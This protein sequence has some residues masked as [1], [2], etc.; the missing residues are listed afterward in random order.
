ME[1]PSPNKN[2]LATTCTP[3][4]YYQQTFH[5]S[6]LQQTNKVR[7]S[8]TGDVST[9][10]EE[11]GVL[12]S[13]QSTHPEWQRVP[14]LRLNK[15][16]RT[17][18][19]PTSLSPPTNNRFSALPLNSSGD[20]E[21]PQKVNKPPP[22]I[23]YGIEDVS[24]LISTLGTV[25]DKS[26]YNIKILSKNQLR[27]S[28]NEADIY[29]TLV[30]FAREKGLIGHT[31]TPKS[32]KCCRLVIKN[33][34]H[35]T[36]TDAIKEEIEK[37]GNVVKGEIINARI[38]PNKNP[39]Y[40]FFVNLEPSEKNK[41]VKNIKY[42]YNTSVK[43]EDPIK[44]KTIVQCNRCQQYGHT[45]NN[46]FRPYRCL[47][48]A[49]DHKTSDCPKKDRT[50]PAKCALCLGD[51]PANYKGCE[52][53]K[54]I[55]KRRSTTKSVSSRIMQSKNEPIPETN[56]TKPNFRLADNINHSETYAEVLRRNGDKNNSNVDPTQDLRSLI[57]E[58][59]KKMDKLMEQMGS[60]F[61]ILTKLMSTFL[62]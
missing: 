47:K 52:V 13:S 35:T 33:L 7:T 31:F 34:H 48:C 55:L 37:T 6:L 60:L 8:S 45:K 49:Q 26:G 12:T 4:K 23:L 39:S 43:I 61:T 14:Q 56:T 16:P 17:S 9:Q 57:I 3:K 38:G 30:S 59:N 10:Q 20:E 22:L 18:T 46:C 19:S 5:P 58:Q 42:I 41:E 11:K 62:K 44:R 15:R 36:P 51:H 2:N 54:E 32:E 21:K 28:C 27:I 25:V 50:S 29:K 40:T 1:V 24:K 53:Y